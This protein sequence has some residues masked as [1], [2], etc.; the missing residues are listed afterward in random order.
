[1]CYPIGGEPIS[2]GKSDNADIDSE[3]VRYELKGQVGLTRNISLPTQ[4]N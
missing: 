4:R 1:M 2:W 3:I